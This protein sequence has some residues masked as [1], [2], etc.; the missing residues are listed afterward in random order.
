MC[1]ECSQIRIVNAPWLDCDSGLYRYTDEN[2]ETCCAIGAG[3]P[4]YNVNIVY[5]SFYGRKLEEENK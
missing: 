5:C 2:G 1:K 3:D 4:A